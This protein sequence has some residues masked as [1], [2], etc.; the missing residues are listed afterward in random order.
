S[1]SRRGTPRLAAFVLALVFITGAITA[2]FHAGGEQGWWA[3][4]ATCMAGNPADIDFGNLSGIL[5]G[6][7]EIDPIISCGDIAW[8][9]MG[10]SMAAWNFIALVLLSALSL[11]AAKRPKDA[12][13]P[14]N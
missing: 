6:T 9:F 14:R 4:P 7:V 8:S 12:R 10:L 11:L 3:L 2:G 13:A 1:R 5:N